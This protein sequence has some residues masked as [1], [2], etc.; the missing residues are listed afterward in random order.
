LAYAVTVP[1]VLVW[2]CQHLVESGLL[3]GPALSVAGS[4]A[5]T[6]SIWLYSVSV[7]AVVLVTRV[8]VLL[9]LSSLTVMNCVAELIKV[10]PG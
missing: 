8:P 10:E 4:A 7:T 2:Q 1:L 9:S 5:E 3:L 6:C